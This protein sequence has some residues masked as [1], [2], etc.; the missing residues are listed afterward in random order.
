M[1]TAEDFVSFGQANVDAFVKSGQIFATGLQDLTK[2]MSVT[3]QASME[4]MMN[5]FRTLSGVKSI[6]EVIDLQT[7][8]T[9]SAVEK[10][11]AHTGHVAESSMKLAEQTIAPIAGRL[12]LAVDSFKQV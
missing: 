12:S 5:T 9:R 11:L 7:T 8:L 6:K 1:K 4:E 10:A 2:Q 3:A